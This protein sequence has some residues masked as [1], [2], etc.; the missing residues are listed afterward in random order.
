MVVSPARP[1]LL[2]V[3]PLV[4]GRWTVIGIDATA[5]VD[6][7]LKYATCYGA[8]RAIESGTVNG[9][10]LR[11]ER[12]PRRM[13]S[14]ISGRARALLVGQVQAQ[15]ARW[16]EEGAERQRSFGETHHRGRAET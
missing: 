15:E 8:A 16:L 1:L 12:G 9:L 10:R 4:P 11:M 13:S 14:V 7:S 6:W 2:L 3:V 5:V